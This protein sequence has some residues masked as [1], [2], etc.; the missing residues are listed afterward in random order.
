MLHSGL[1]ADFEKHLGKGYTDRDVCAQLGVS[2]SSF[3][4]W[5]NIAEAIRDER[6]YPGVPEDD[7]QRQLFLDLLDGVTRARAAANRVA[8]DS[9]RAGMTKT[10]TTVKT[11]DVYTET[12]V[13]KHTGEL[14]E[15]KE[16]RIITTKTTHPG[17]WRAAI[18]YLK[19]RD[20]EHW[21]EKFEHAIILPDDTQKMMDEIG[22]S[23]EQLQDAIRRMLEKRAAQDAQAQ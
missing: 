11:E 2:K 4:N 17:D 15:H 10:V 21:S 5:L 8:V 19:R 20:P 3:Y 14:Y 18:E 12:R 1:V 23:R 7:E 22:I 9:L 16:T 6:D 13:N